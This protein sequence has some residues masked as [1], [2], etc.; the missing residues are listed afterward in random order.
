[1]AMSGR[2]EALKEM[3]ETGDEQVQGLYAHACQ[4][5]EQ[6]RLEEAEKLFRFLCIY[7]FYNSHYWMGL[8]AVYQVS[9]HYRKAMELYAVAFAQD[10]GDYRPMFYTGECQLALGAHA[11]AR[12]CFDYVLRHAAD[13]ELPRRSRVYL[14]DLSTDVLLS[15]SEALCGKTSP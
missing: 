6:G 7:D 2:K 9:G 5:H 14:E 8:A 1:M 10:R 12:D 15:C 3:S 11:K 4:F 13:G